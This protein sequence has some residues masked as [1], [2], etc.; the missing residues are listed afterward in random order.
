MRTQHTFI[1]LLSLFLVQVLMQTG[2]TQTTY[3]DNLIMFR[4]PLA[5]DTNPALR[6]TLQQA[7]VAQKLPQVRVQLADYWH[8]YLQ[9]IRRGHRGIYLTEPHLASWAIS[10]HSF[11]PI[12]QIKGD[13]RFVLLVRSDDTHLFEIRDLE[14]KTICAERPLSLNSLWL[15]ELFLNHP[16]ISYRLKTVESSI[17]ALKENQA[18][19]DAFSVNDHH[20]NQVANHLSV[21]FIRIQQSRNYANPSIITDPET[22]KKLGDKLTTFFKS[23]LAY[24]SLL[25]VLTHYEKEPYLGKHK[26]KTNQHLLKQLT[27]YWG[28]QP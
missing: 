11:V 12:T 5:S 25:P 14:Q 15:S 8:S 28:K 22:M 9:S 20:F 2:H 6:H 1:L 13:L 19:C 27:V 21:A 24:D 26:T 16:S 23:D 10:H 3:G 18:D 17:K 7:L 4:L